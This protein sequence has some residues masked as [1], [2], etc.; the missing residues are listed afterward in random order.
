MKGNTPIAWLSAVVVKAIWKSSFLVEYK[1]FR[2][3]DDKELLREI[4]DAKHIRLCPPNASKVKFDLLDEV[5]AFYGN[6]WL[7]GVVAK[8][9]T[10][11]KYR[12]YIAHWGEEREFSH[13]ELRLRYDLVDGQWVKASQVVRMPQ[14]YPSSAFFSCCVHFHV[15]T[16]S[17]L[18]QNCVFILCS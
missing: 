2:N 5:E 17:I 14:I 6:G 9:Y 10:R 3:L 1:H 12:V 7:P 15:Y 4:V 18:T 16:S 8:I 11:S 13:T